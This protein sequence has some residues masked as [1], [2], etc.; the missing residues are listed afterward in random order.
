MLANVSCLM[1]LS[2]SDHTYSSMI[3]LPAPTHAHTAFQP[4]EDSRCQSEKL[5][6]WKSKKKN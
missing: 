5:V 3:A 1:S 2:G 4:H 6:P